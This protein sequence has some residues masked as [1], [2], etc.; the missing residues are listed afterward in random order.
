[1]KFALSKKI[2]AIHQPNYFPW[3][4]YFSK[5]QKADA[6]VFLDNVDITLHSSK[7]ITHR[8]K[9]NFLG[10][11]MWLTLPLEK[12]ETKEISQLKIN[13][14]INWQEK[15]IQIIKQAYA[16]A[17]YFNEVFPTIT[18]LIYYNENNLS[19]FNIYIIKEIAKL[20]QI[21]TAFYVASELGVI[22]NN[23]TLR[24]IKICK[25][26]NGIVYLS[27]MGGKKYH[28][29][30]LFNQNNIEVK[31]TNFVVREYKHHSVFVPGL[32]VLDSLFEC[33]YNTSNLL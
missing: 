21:K 30:P 13:F 20:L 17:P 11:P 8:T 14:N 9:I 1:M 19:K 18:K 25:K 10:K 7:A 15:Q 32:S 3:L 31:Y 28:N 6:F 16:K 29:E 27:G 23:P 5:L 2:I 24:L 22:E 33:G 26:L 4:G 12:T